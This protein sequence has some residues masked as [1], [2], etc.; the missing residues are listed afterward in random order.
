[1]RQSRNTGVVG[2]ASY[3]VTPALHKVAAGWVDQEMLT[4]RKM[5]VD[6]AS[7]DE[8]GAA[9]G[10]EPS[11]VVRFVKK[12]N[13]VWNHK[14]R[15]NSL[16][17]ARR[18]PVGWREQAT[19]LRLAG[20]SLE[21]ISQAVGVTPTVVG[22]HL[23]ETCVPDPKLRVGRLPSGNAPRPISNRQRQKLADAAIRKRGEG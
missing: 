1:M 4:I 22:V 21:E 6:G 16:G 3:M 20:K 7:A 8:I 19:E 9:L 10:W 15:G 2:S 11:K 13:L 23:K 18:G 14:M 12:N 17:A 5:A